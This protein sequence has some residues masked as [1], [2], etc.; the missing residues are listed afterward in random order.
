MIGM[1]KLVSRTGNVENFIDPTAKIGEGTNVWHYAVVL[2]D[3]VIG[4]ECSIGSHCEIGRGSKIGSGARISNGVF[5]PSNSIIGVG[6]F[7]GPGVIFTDDK[8][9]VSGNVGYKSEP[10]CVGD[11]ASIGAGAVI[12]PGV[13]IGC[14]A[15]IGAGSIVT[16]EVPRG[17]IIRGDPSRISRCLSVNS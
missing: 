10:P 3:V 4:S 7:I 6:V 9:P 1:I 11:W 2:A 12:L 16:R 17:T 13:V 5:L 14:N 15:M 8:Y